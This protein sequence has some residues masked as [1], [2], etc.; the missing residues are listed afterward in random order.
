MKLF[1]EVDIRPLLLVPVLAR[2]HQLQVVAACAQSLHQPRHSHCDAVDLRRV[3]LGHHRNAQRLRH[4][5]IG[6]A[7]RVVGGCGVQ[8]HAA[9]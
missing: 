1:Q 9:S 7:A 4:R 5:H 6:A 2:P 8:S 3:G